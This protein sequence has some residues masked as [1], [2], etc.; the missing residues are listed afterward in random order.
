MANKLTKEECLID[1]TKSNRDIHNLVRGICRSPGAYFKH[2]DKIIKVIETTAVD[3]V[4]ENGKIIKAGKDG[5]DIGC[6]QGLVRLIKVKPEGK[7][8]MLARDWY[9]GIR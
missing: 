8:E 3:G 5:V 4:G 2:N 7:G 1:W 6:G 9:N